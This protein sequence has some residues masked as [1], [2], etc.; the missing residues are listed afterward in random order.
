VKRY[1]AKE[2]IVT[3]LNFFAALV[4]LCL[5]NGDSAN[6]GLGGLTSWSDCHTGWDRLDR[7]ENVAMNEHQIAEI[8]RKLLELNRGA[9]ADGEY[10]IA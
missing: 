2:F 3:S 5:M 4:G 1:K 9:F 7:R 6:A 8:Y 10:E